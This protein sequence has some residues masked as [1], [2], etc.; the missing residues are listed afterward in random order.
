MGKGGVMMNY[1]EAFAMITSQYTREELEHICMGLNKSYNIFE[2][3]N[4]RW[5]KIA[6]HFF[7]TEEKEICTLMKTVLSNRFINDLMLKFYI[8]ERVVKY[9]LIKNMLRLTNDIV[10][11]EMSIGD[12]RI[13]VCRI[14]G[15]SYA[16]EIKTQY[17]SFERLSGQMT[18]Y[19]KAFE[20][21][22]VVIPRSKVIDIQAHIPKGCGIITYRQSAHHE[23]VFSYYRRSN[24]N[25]CDVKLCISSLSSSDLSEFLK[26]AGLKNYGSKEEKLKTILSFSEHYNIL[27]IYRRLLKEKYKTNWQFLKEHFEQILPIDVQSFFSAYI[28]PSLLYETQKECS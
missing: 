9:F 27:P 19:M 6:Y 21:V 12:S 2:P 18:D 16:Y 1:Q 24:K 10:A 23:L 7:R 20:R 4:I 17:D 11:F 3:E 5:K 22:Y 28:E 25:K 26:L 14:N 13:D 8:C 15:G